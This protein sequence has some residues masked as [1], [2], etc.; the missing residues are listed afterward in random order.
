MLSHRQA[1]TFY[2][3]FGRKQDWQGFYEDAAV[4]ALLLH[5]DL[6][7]AR[8][9][10][11][12]G[13]GTGRMAATLL[14]GS[15]PAEACYLG[16][17]IS[18]TMVALAQERLAPFGARAQVRL[19]NGSPRLDIGEGT[20][21]RFLSTYVLDLLSWEDIRLLLQ[22]AQRVL[23]PGGLLGLVSL[24]HGFTPGSRLV[25]HLW[26]ALHAL[27]PQLVGGCRPVSLSE[28]IAG[29]AWKLRFHDRLSRWGLASEVLVAEKPGAGNELIRGL[30]CG[31]PS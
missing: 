20:F 4:N 31:T 29:P 23:A 15:L 24:T 13:C 21:D 5:A 26:T 17:D 14:A 16:I 3:R 12:F 8:A 27:H 28:L 2:D 10:F 25:E 30:V 6:G 19:A 22:E 9:V 11:E 7:Q 1:K 18:E